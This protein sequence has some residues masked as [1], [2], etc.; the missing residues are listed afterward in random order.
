MHSDGQGPAPIGERLRSLGRRPASL[1]NA[2]ASEAYGNPEVRPGERSPDPCTHA[3]RRT[4]GSIFSPEVIVFPC[5]APVNSTTIS[6][7]LR[8]SVFAERRVRLTTPSP[9]ERCLQGL[10]PGLST[11]TIGTSGQESGESA[12]R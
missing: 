3:C 6:L 10:L 12:T 11:A 7:S 4:R 2:V 1:G 8:H 9:S 5:V